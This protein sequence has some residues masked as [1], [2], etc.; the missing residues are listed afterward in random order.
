MPKIT[1][2]GGASNDALASEADTELQ[3]D[4]IV[5]PAPEEESSP[6]SNSATSSPTQQSSD[7]PKT[8]NRRSRARTTANPS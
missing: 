7:E 8:P 3:D 6:G 5:Q 1:V 2:H 4:V